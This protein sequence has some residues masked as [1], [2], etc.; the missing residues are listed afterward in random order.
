MD[1]DRI[2]KILLRVI[3]ALAV[4]AVVAIAL[5]AVNLYNN[6]WT[7]FPWCTALWYPGV[8]FYIPLAVLSAVY[9]V[10]KR[11]WKK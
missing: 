3:I 10:L 5:Q 11:P 7:S 6:Q 9:L 4:L 8:G 2:A 1:K